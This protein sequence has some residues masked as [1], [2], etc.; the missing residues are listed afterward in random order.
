MIKR[1][2]VDAGH[3]G[4]FPGAKGKV[5]GL[6]EKD[7]TLAVALEIARQLPGSWLTRD[8]DINFV[9]NSLRDIYYRAELIN[10]K[11]ADLVI[12]VHV[13]SSDKPGP[14]YMS[15][16]VAPGASASRKYAEA[17][18]AELVATTGWPDGGVREAQFAILK[19][20]S[21][22]ALLVEL[23]FISNKEHEAQLARP[24]FRVKLAGA[25]ARAVTKI[26]GT[27]GV[28][29]APTGY[30]ALGSDVHILELGSDYDTRVDLGKPGALEPL[31]AIVKA[32]G[33]WAGINLG[34]FDPKGKVEHY[35]L[36]VQNDGLKNP[37]NQQMVE[38]IMTTEGKLIVRDISTNAEIP[39]GTK[40]AAGGSFALVI[41]GKK[42]LLKAELYSHAKSREPRT[43]LGQKANGNLL[44]VVVDGRR[45]P[46]LPGMTADELAA[47]MLQLGAVNAINYDGGGSSELIVGGA[48]KN[49]PSDGKERA[50]GSAL[51]VY[52]KAVVSPQVTIDAR[53]KI[54]PAKIENGRTVGETAPL[55]DALAIPWSWNAKNKQLVIK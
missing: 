26:N 7:V 5:L 34:Y 35:G 36:L 25:I 49:L 29:P 23:G 16:W 55:L 11:G 46:K 9:D 40:W 10:S 38:A 21:M 54:L 50:I 8:K 32:G 43:A 47:L 22:P 24:E 3:G 17:I 14:N 1:T 37:P 52:N 20:T 53:G 31:S 44:L 39:T 41:D 42:N 45:P 6:L 51:L 19:K 4:A 12:A 30:R 18:Q 2:S 15:T 48:I 28:T 27:Q 33:A 13:N